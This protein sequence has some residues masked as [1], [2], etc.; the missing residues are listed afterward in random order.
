MPALA[1]PPGVI[2]N[3]IDPPNSDP[4]LIAVLL[5]CTILTTILVFVRLYTKICLLKS[6]GWDDSWVVK[7]AGLGIHQWDILLVDLMNFGKVFNYAEIY[8][9]PL[10]FVVK[11]SILLQFMRIFVPH[12]TGWM[13]YL[14]HLNVWLNLVC[15]LG[16]FLATI[17]QC[18][19]RDKIWN[20]TISG[21][22]SNHHAVLIVG[23]VINV[24]SDFCILFIPIRSVWQLQ[25]SQKRKIG[26][27]AIFGVGLLACLSA[28]ILPVQKEIAR[29]R[30]HDTYTEF[31]GAIEQSFET[32]VD[33]GSDG[34]QSDEEHVC[35]SGG[36][37][38]SR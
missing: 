7:D 32:V 26:I 29:F 11:L 3:F 36:G 20:P 8:Y 15:Y 23:G 1:P 28:V 10:I 9:S 37:G 21:H 33:S 35:D 2:P 14:I 25:M 38:G 27:S 16:I 13:Y 17:L 19:P 31:K 18:I 6:H 22:C 12:R 30:R 24:I 5:T 34:D 4:K